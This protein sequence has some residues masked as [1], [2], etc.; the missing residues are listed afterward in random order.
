MTF[1]MWTLSTAAS[2]NFLLYCF[3]SIPVCLFIVNHLSPIPL[4]ICLYFA[5]VIL[6]IFLDRLRATAFQVAALVYPLHNTIYIFQHG[7]HQAIGIPLCGIHWNLTN[8]KCS[9]IGIILDICAQ[10]HTFPSHT[11]K[12]ILPHCNYSTICSHF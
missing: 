2:L 1:L 7:L 6:V 8:S 4:Q 12:G 3:S 9:C 11:R 10:P 5:L